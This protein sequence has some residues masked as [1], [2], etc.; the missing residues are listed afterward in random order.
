MAETKKNLPSVQAVEP[1]PAPADA[2]EPE[3]TGPPAALLLVDGGKW[4][5]GTKAKANNVVDFA[6]PILK[7]QPYARKHY[8]RLFV[9]TSPHDTFNM[10]LWHE[11]AGRPRYRWV[12]KGRGVEYGYL[13]EGAPTAQQI[14][15]GN[16][17]HSWT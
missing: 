4:G 10:P 14:E 8:G 2:T 7:G 11:D 9:T 13:V 3:P 17:E 6:E 15:E 16:K 12:S 5:S 1:E